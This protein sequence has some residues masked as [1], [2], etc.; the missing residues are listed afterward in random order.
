MTD[1]TITPA[2]VWKR[3]TAEQRLRAAEALWRNDEARG[4][5]QAAALAIAKHLKFRPKSVTALALDRK[6]R[7]LAAVPELPDD[8][9]AHVL[10][11]YHLADQR[12]MMSAFLDA[13]GIAHDQG[14]IEQDAVSPDPAKIGAAVAAIRESYPP[15]DVSLYLETLISQDPAAWGVLREV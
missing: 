9:A 3:M 7:Y 4:D 8:L 14:T 2:R 6:A 1:Q 13:L 5:Q 15:A 11:A 10:V 12:P